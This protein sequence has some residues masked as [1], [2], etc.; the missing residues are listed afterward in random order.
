M[1][2]S[3]EDGVGGHLGKAGICISESGQSLRETEG[4]WA[5][6]HDGGRGGRA[7]KQKQE[8]GQLPGRDTGFSRRHAP[9][10]GP[11][12]VELQIRGSC[13]GS[14]LRGRAKRRRLEPLCHLPPSAAGAGQS[15]GGEPSG[16]CPSP[17]AELLGDLGLGPREVQLS[18]PARLPPPA[19]GAH[20]A[21]APHLRLSFPQQPTPSSWDTQHP[22]SHSF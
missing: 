7:P 5:P 13:Q 22:S 10:K 16:D 6:A 2:R 15:R 18:T 1:S 14:A 11:V 20:H 8:P 4:G 17:G 12:P 19:S 21:C 9:L 3:L